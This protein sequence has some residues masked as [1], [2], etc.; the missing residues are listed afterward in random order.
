[1][2]AQSRGFTIH[3][4]ARGAGPPLV[5]VPGTLSS[6][7]HWELFGYVEALCDRYRVISVDPLGHGRSDKPHD[8]GAY[9][10]AGVTADLLAVLDGEDAGRATIWGYSRGGWITYGLAA[11][12]PE[13]VQRIVVGGFASHAH[14]AE[15]PMQSAWIEALGAGDWASFWRTFKIEDAGPLAPIEEANDPLA[16]A[17][18]VAG[19]QRPTRYVDLAGIRCPSFHYVGDRDPIARHVRADAR[20]LGA[21]VEVCPEATHLTA[22]ANAEPAMA[23]VSS[24]LVPDRPGT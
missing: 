20:T 8:P 18:A 24:W 9:A 6:A 4:E 17:A 7:A 14:K 5:L 1:V 3:Y 22:F 12:H 10:A 15:M 11:E 13:R 19:S 16:I 23:A 2:H 21:P